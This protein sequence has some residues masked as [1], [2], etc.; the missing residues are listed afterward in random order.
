MKK[1]NLIISTAV[2]L[3]AIS[4]GKSASSSQT[5]PSNS[6][7]SSM[8]NSVLS[9]Q[10]DLLSQDSSLINPNGYKVYPKKGTPN[11]YEV[12]AAEKG[13]A[14][15]SALRDVITNNINQLGCENIT[16]SM[17]ESGD[18]NEMILLEWQGST[19]TLNYNPWET[20][21]N[22]LQKRNPGKKFVMDGENEHSFA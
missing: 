12:S 17:Y 8:Q 10:K 16:P 4:C 14:T 22:D 13:E 1:F 2:C 11:V 3:N 15:I 18:L 19:A 9:S 21:I 5:V 6:K 20:E 7:S